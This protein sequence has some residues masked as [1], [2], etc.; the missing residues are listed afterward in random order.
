MGLT[1]WAAAASEGL[2]ALAPAVTATQVH[3]A[4][5]GGG[6]WGTTRRWSG[7]RRS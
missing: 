3:G 7:A 4:T 2:G 6:P 5:F 1:Q